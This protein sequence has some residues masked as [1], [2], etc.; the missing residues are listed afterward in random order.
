M[1]AKREE[2]PHFLK[3]FMKPKNKYYCEDCGQAVD[4]RE[5]NLIGEHDTIKVSCECGKCYMIGLRKD[6]E[7]NL[8]YFVYP[9]FHAETVSSIVERLLAYT[10]ALSFMVKD[11][12]VKHIR[13]DRWKQARELLARLTTKI[14]GNEKLVIFLTENMMI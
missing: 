2:F 10:P 5:E 9:P 11:E 1:T 7:G 6:E 3:N 8:A 12:L 13:F 14:A 4:V